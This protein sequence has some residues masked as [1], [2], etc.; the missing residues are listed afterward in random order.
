MQVE[1]PNRLEHDADTLSR[2][3]DGIDSALI[4]T[5]SHGRIVLFNQGSEALTGYRGDEVSGNA[6]WEVFLDPEDQAAAREAIANPPARLEQ[7]WAIR[8]GSHRYI[9]WATAPLP[10]KTDAASYRLVTVSDLSGLIAL[11]KKLKDS[12]KRY[13][14]L[15]H[16]MTETLGIYSSCML[17]ENGKVTYVNE[18]FC[19]LVGYSRTELVGKPL[20]ILLDEENR[21]IYDEFLVC[22]THDTIRTHEL[23]FTHRDGHPIWTIFSSVPTFDRDHPI[24]GSIGV[25]IDISEVKLAERALR[26]SNAELDAFAHTVAHDLKG[27]L[28]VIHGFSS[29]LED[30][31]VDIPPAEL[32]D[33]LH[34]I[35]RN[36]DKM[37]NI[38]D[39]LLLL[40]QMR[41][42]DVEIET[43]DM[44][45]IVASARERVSYIAEQYSAEIAGPDEWPQA[46]GYG[47]WI[48]EVWV[49]YISNGIKYGGQMPSVQVGA[50]VE[51]NGMVRFWVRDN[52]NGI[53][54]EDVERL[55]TPFTRLNQV[56]AKGHGLGLSI[57]QR[58]VG[59]LGG[60]V[61]AR[62]EVGSGSEFSFT[63]PAAP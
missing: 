23:V 5:D 51:D 44:A 32:Q 12:E 48:E 62:S 29:L 50:T 20:G 33:Y 19:E 26:D 35:S 4:V 47:P 17:N 31:F 36:T 41:Q 56:R 45:A 57:V 54:P 55:F 3:L 63:L 37:I 15:L 22:E 40:A 9:R 18:E 30:T 49:N 60:E 7:H 6:L 43:L 16:T 61:N 53:K 2:T 25:A 52:G 38:V 8:D 1:E 13:Q 10:G 34:T 14:Q 21:R 24:E 58:I 11:E 27:P 39:E 42:L 59:K 28:A 46:L